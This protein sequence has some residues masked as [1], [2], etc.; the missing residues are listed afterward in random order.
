MLQY[1]IVGSA[2]TEPADTVVDTRQEWRRIS[3]RRCA[4]THPNNLE[5]ATVRPYRFSVSARWRP[6]LRGHTVIK[7]EEAHA[8]R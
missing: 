6:S 3:W 4:V 7:Q 1:F 5:I 2:D 8:L